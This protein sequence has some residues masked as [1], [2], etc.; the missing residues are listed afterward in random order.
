MRYLKLFLIAIVSFV[1]LLPAVFFNW[2]TN[3]ISEIDNR[4]LTEFPTLNKV[5]SDTF[6]DIYKFIMI[7]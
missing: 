1:I 5:N 2:K 4:K 3:Y 7:E 6:K